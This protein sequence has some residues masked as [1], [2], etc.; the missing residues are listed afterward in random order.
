MDKI[1]KEYAQKNENTPWY[2]EFKNNTQF[3]DKIKNKT[4]NLSTKHNPQKT[5]VASNKRYDYMQMINFMISI[6]GEIRKSV[7]SSYMKCYNIPMLWRKLFLSIAK[8]R[9]YNK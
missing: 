5:T 3:F 2:I 7:I 1:L 8:N 9:K 6:K 4:K